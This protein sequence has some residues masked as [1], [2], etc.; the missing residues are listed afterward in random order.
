M[1]IIFPLDSFLD[2]S[3]HFCIYTFIVDCLSVSLL[4]VR[5]LENVEFIVSVLRCVDLEFMC[6]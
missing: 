5:Y 2:G 3:L 4:S 1:T 6:S